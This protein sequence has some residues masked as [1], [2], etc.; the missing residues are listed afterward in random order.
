[1]LD[2]RHE[3]SRRTR[4]PHFVYLRYKSISTF[5]CCENQLQL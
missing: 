2:I 5:P 4:T 3:N 1:M